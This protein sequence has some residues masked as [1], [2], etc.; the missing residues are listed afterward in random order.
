MEPSA[1][2]KIQPRQYYRKFLEAGVRPS[3]RALADWRKTEI[4]EVSSRHAESLSLARIGNTAVMCGIKLEV[5]TPHATYPKAGRMEVQLTLKPICSSTFEIGADS[6]VATSLGKFLTN[7]MTQTPCFDPQQLGIQDG[8]SCWVIFA[9]C[10]CL[11]YDGNVLDVALLAL[12][13]A[14]RRLVLPH[15]VI[16][17]DN[18]SLPVMINRR[19]P[20]TPFK[21]RQCAIPITF[22]AIDEFYVADPCLAEEELRDASWTVIYNEEGELLSVYKPG[23]TGVSQAQMLACMKYGKGRIRELAQLLAS[24]SNS[25]SSL[26]TSSS[27][28]VTVHLPEL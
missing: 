1:I 4:S 6:E 19:V 25:C 24:T 17:D 27:S 3:G 2:H 10:V 13:A 11:N 26:L 15:V 8:K 9:D 12:N 23:G 20:G 22:A 16:D 7:L 5:G 28:R 21:L 18:P 14:L